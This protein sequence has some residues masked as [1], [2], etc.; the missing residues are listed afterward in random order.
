MRL[1][2]IFVILLSTLA[3]SPA[4]STEAVTRCFSEV[5]DCIDG[6]IASF[7]QAQGGLPV[8]GYPIG[9]ATV[10]TGPNGPI[11]VQRFERTQIEYHAN[12][13]PPYDIQLGR[14]GADLLSE[15]G[16]IASAENPQPGCRFFDETGLNLC[17]PFLS[18]YGQYGLELG[19]PGISPRE[20]LAL[21]GLPLSAP[22]REQPSD[23]Q[24]Y[25]VQWFER[26]RFE[27]HGPNGVQFGLL[28][29]EIDQPLLQPEGLTPG[30]FIL[31]EGSQLTRLG[32]PVIIKGVNYYPQG[33]P[34]REMWQRW[35]A[36][37]IEQFRRAYRGL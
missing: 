14:L 4:R 11:T 32:Q 23:G 28:G 19:D 21:F 37:Q 10:V 8:F 31:A 2:L 7:W 12:Q 27:D 17:E 9:P 35:D 24:T 1:L 18:A 26:A 29:R 3:L 6:P 20:S 36:H 13:A 30:G 5:S 33:R 25:T 34:W 16:L 15:R 22:R